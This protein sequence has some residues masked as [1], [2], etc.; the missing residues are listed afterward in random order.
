MS[1]VP[2]FPK[3]SVP[4]E[5]GS[6]IRWRPVAIL[7]LSAGFLIAEVGLA[8]GW[9]STS[10]P[11]LVHGVALCFALL[12][13][14][15]TRVKVDAYRGF[16]RFA[17]F[18]TILMITLLGASLD[19]IVTVPVFYVWPLLAAGYLL[20]RREVLAFSLFAI[21]G[22]AI[23]RP[24]PELGLADYLSVLIV[25]SVVIVAVRILA[26]NL[27]RT[28]GTLRRTSFTDPLTGLLNRRSLYYRFEQA[29]GRCVATGAPLSTLLLDIDH[30]KQ[31]NDQHGHTTGDQAL[32]RFS[33]LLV[34]SFRSTD[35]I[36][37]IGGE[38]FAVVMPGTTASDAEAIASRFG[39]ALRQDRSIPGVR[40]TTS[41]GIASLEAAS[42]GWEALLRAADDAVYDAK[43]AGRDRILLAAS[44]RMPHRLQPH[45]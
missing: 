12:A 2:P 43:R 6:V 10:Q 20:S 26:E 27:G 45:D 1:L 38:E 42:E 19:G 5:T 29:Y 25:S 35:F 36:A 39:T 13:G 16:A 32:I 41:G 23:G 18:T 33:E 8:A 7:M 31:I 28:I 9:V 30:F 3:P 17:I 40:M 24:S 22:C 21:A 15:V 44:R 37:R 11:A 4:V 14:A 34:G